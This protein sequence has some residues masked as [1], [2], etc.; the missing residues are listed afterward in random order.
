MTITRLP[1]SKALALAGNVQ[2]G[3]FLGTGADQDRVITGRHAGQFDVP[4]HFDA[5][6]ELDAGSEEQALVGIDI[7]LVQPE[8]GDA[9]TEDAAD[10]R[11]RVGDAHLGT[12]AIQP[13]RGDDA[14]GAGS[15]QRDAL[16]GQEVRL[17]LQRDAEQVGIGDFLFDLIPAYR[18]LLDIQ[19]AVAKTELPPVAYAGGDG[20]QG[21][22]VEKD[23][24]RFV[25]LVFPVELHALGNGRMDRT[26]LQGAL[27]LLAQEA[28]ERFVV[29]HKWL[30]W[31]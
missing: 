12:E 3:R 24:A 22:V 9:V 13:D 11:I 8:S 7:F 25:Q 23:L 19:D 28:A 16:S 4:A 2:Q 29:F 18:N 30:L 20:G 5:P 27:G 15:D 6:L 31:L 14:H 10:A 26:S 17:P 1:R 21:I